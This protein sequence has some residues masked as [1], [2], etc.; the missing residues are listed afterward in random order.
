MFKFVGLCNHRAKEREK[1]TMRN[2]FLYKS[3]AS[4]SSI[5]KA[6]IN[7]TM[8]RKLN[9]ISCEK[10]IDFLEVQGI[11]FDNISWFYAYLSHIQSVRHYPSY[12]ETFFAFYDDR[13]FAISQSKIFR[14]LRIDFTS[15]FDKKSVWRGIIESQESLFKLHSLVEITNTDDSEEQCQEL[16]MSTG[17]IH[18]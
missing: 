2:T 5:C 1:S 17:C 8:S 9:W 12:S 6:L 10:F 7:E 16:L 3:H 4:S 14:E 13:L 18:A 11:S 15:S